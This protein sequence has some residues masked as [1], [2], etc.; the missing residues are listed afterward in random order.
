[1]QDSMLRFKDIRQDP[2]D[3]PTAAYQRQN[4]EEVD[5]V[6]QSDAGSNEDERKRPSCDCCTHKRINRVG[7]EKF[8]LTESSKIVY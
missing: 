1:M 8:F 4:L 6:A 3:L 2:L 7:Q 5:P